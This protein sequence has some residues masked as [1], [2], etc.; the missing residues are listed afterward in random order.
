MILFVI[1]WQ[2]DAFPEVRKDP[3]H[4]KDIINEEEA[5]FLKTLNRGR[6][7]LERTI[8]KLDAGATKVPGIFF[9]WFRFLL[10]V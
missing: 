8:K 7:V 1:F 5:Q 4:V 2:G 3:D 6:R 10:F 9:V